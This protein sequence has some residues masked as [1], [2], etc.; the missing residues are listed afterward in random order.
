MSE[1]C[2]CN[3]YD[4]SGRVFI[5]FPAAL[6][7]NKSNPQLRANDGFWPEGGRRKAETAAFGRQQPIT[8]GSYGSNSDGLAST[9]TNDDQTSVCSAI[10]RASSTSIPRYLTVLSSFV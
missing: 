8:K 1:I 3:Y 4:I 2:N 7:V 6:R 10:S 5:K 9:V